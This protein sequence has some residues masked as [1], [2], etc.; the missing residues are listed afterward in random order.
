M[1]G[2][3]DATFIAT[4]DDEFI[5]FDVFKTLNHR[6]VNTEF[7][8]WKAVH[9]GV[10]KLTRRPDHAFGSQ[11][12]NCCVDA[13]IVADLCDTKHLDTRTY[14]QRK[15]HG[16]IAQVRCVRG[17]GGMFDSQAECGRNTD[18]NRIQVQHADRVGRKRRGNK[19]GL[20]RPASK[21]GTH[22]IPIQ[23]AEIL[24]ARMLERYR[25]T[26]TRR[27]CTH[28]DDVVSMRRHG[29]RVLTFAGLIKLRLP[30]EPHR[31]PIRLGGVG[32]RTATK[33]QAPPHIPNRSASTNL[34]CA[35]CVP[36][37]SRCR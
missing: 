31:C 13:E 2:G 10:L 23:Y 7:T 12:F 28:D 4:D 9:A 32:L 17:A 29:H 1:I 14:R 3:V 16:H 34:G 27:A 18:G 25:D 5:P 6:R 33:A 19:P 24:D 15:E 8:P 30:Q 36:C 26:D 21:R 22:T 35:R 11:R 37:P 20:C